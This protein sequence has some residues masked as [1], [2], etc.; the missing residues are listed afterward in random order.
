MLQ[1]ARNQSFDTS[2]KVPN[3]SH[4][5][6]LLAKSWGT[7]IWTPEYTLKF[8]EKI[9]FAL[10]IDYESKSTNHG[11]SHSHRTARGA[12]EKRLKGEYVKIET[13]KRN[14]RP[15]YQELKVWPRINLS[16]AR[17]LCPFAH[18][19]VVAIPVQKAA[20]K[21][22]QLALP[23]EESKPQ[24]DV[25]DASDRMTRKS[26]SKQ[27]QPTKNDLKVSSEKQCGYCEICRTEYDVLSTHLQSKEHVNFVKNAD[28]FLAL[29]TLITNSA[30]VNS[31]LSVNKPDKAD[32]DSGLFGKRTSSKKVAKLFRSNDD[33]PNLQI[34]AAE[35]VK[36]NGSHPVSSMC[37]RR[38]NTRR[39]DSVP[40]TKSP[41]KRSPVKPVPMEVDDDD[42]DEKVYNAIA[43]NDETVPLIKLRTRRESAK[44]INY[45]EPKEDEDNS[46][47]SKIQQIRIRGIRWRPPS[48]DSPTA[49]SQHQPV[50][51]KVVDPE[52]GVRSAR[53]NRSGAHSRTE[54]TAE[55]NNQTSTTGIKVRI[56]RVRESE[57]SLLTNEADNFMFPRI[58]SDQPTDEDRQSTPEP[59][60]LSAEIVSS[61]ADRPR[62]T[63]ATT[64]SPKGRVRNTS[65]SSGRDLDATNKRTRR[66]QLEAF[67]AD[68]S[69]Y[70]KFDNP[71]SRLRFQEAPFQPSLI[72]FDS[73][74]I[75]GAGGGGVG[76]G[77]SYSTRSTM[78]ATQ[79]S[80]PKASTIAG[81]T[82]AESEDGKGV[83]T[84]DKGKLLKSDIVKR[85]KFAFERIPSTEPWFEAFQRQDE[86][87]ERIFEYWGSTG[88]LIHQFSYYFNINR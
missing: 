56:C 16:G 15:Y 83:N 76:V 32:I 49:I 4:S 45:A 11:T 57:L 82:A 17:G 87:R 10:K 88:S 43:D 69:D 38:S 79:L 60:D 80:M 25:K 64:S 58:T 75:A 47:D 65:E 13:F 8:L 6:V 81:A 35:F 63:V 84:Y 70:Y 26:R 86:C 53:S 54:S 72:R 12:N 39:T 24:T 66:K 77:A 18:K 21:Q 41:A 62:P 48:V 31:F 78:I 85:H 5:P 73:C 9:K 23:D 2:S 51:Y 37:T 61:E 34:N 28:N 19:I 71:D 27:L 42:D 36:L 33:K 3:L 29:D 7:P 50:V 67:V 68:N 59:T 14:Y 20:E 44:R 30:S 55:S 46:N 74:D 22:T 40:G 52:S 1:R